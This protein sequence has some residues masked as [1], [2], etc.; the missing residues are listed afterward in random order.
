MSWKI[1]LHYFL[2]FISKPYAE[3]PRSAQQILAEKIQKLKLKSISQL[4][5]CFDKFIPKDCLIPSESG[6]SSRNRFFSKENTFWAFFSQVLDADGGCQEVVRKLQAYATVRSKPLLSSSTSAYCQARIRLDQESLKE[7]LRNTSQ[8][9]Q[10]MVDTG[11]LKGRRVVVVDGTGVSIPDTEK[12]QKVWPQL[13]SQKPGCGF[14]QAAIC[15]CFCLQTGA[16]LS[17]EVGNNKSHELP[18]LRK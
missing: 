7:I 4:S 16:L 8:R 6:Q 17:Y 14:P 10:E 15:A 11:R 2:A 1:W 3:S 18:M 12:N 13:A 9:L 5:V